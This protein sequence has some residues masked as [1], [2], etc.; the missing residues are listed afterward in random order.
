[1]VFYKLWTDCGSF[2]FKNHLIQMD[3]ITFSSIA[4]QTLAC[5][6]AASHHLQAWVILL[7]HITDFK[8]LDT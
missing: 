2:V 4:I 8:N 6:F 5:T 3:H 1:M 7:T